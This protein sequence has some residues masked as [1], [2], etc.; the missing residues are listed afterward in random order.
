MEKQKTRSDAWGTEDLPP[1]MM[2]R[3]AVLITRKAATAAL[4][5]PS[6]DSTGSFRSVCVLLDTLLIA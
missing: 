5:S 4:E 3:S 6:K 2:L 1:T